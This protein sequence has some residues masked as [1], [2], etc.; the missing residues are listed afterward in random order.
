MIHRLPAWHSNRFTRLTK[1]P[2]LHLVDPALA[3]PA[4]GVSP[5]VAFRSGDLIGRLIETFVAQLR[6][7]VG[8]PRLAMSA[9]G[10]RNHLQIC[11]TRAAG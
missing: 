8:E 10:I 3:A 7:L 5:E 1:G 2:K 9:N 4:A 6:P 11:R